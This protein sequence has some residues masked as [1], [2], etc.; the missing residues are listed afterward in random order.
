VHDFDVSIVESWTPR[1]EYFMY[2]TY[3]ELR[4]VDI[5][6]KGLVRSDISDLIHLGQGHVD[7]QTN[8]LNKMIAEKTQRCNLTLARG[9]NE[10]H[11]VQVIPGK[12]PYHK[13]LVMFKFMFSLSDMNFS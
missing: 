10:Y 5:H 8:S 7:M 12:L 6:S 9:A 2:K 11:D 1:L 3:A 13:K 4:L